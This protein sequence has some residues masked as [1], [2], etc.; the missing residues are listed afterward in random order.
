MMM[1]QVQ[2][3]RA[4]GEL[5]KLS[6]AAIRLFTTHSPEVLVLPDCTQIEQAELASAL[7]EAATPT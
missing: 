2:I 5:R 4:A 7:T 3:A 6:P 1:A